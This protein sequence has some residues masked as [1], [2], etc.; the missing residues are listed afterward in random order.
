LGSWL[1]KALL[2]A[3]QAGFNPGT[4]LRKM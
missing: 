1:S 3:W 2:A 4:D